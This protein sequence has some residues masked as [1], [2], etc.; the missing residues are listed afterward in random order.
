MEHWQEQKQ[1][2]YLIYLLHLHKHKWNFTAAHQRT[3]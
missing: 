1:D 2:Y 3:S